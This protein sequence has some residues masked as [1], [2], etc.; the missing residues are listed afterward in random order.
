MVFVWIF[1]TGKTLWF[2]RS[3]NRCN[4]VIR[5]SGSSGYFFNIFPDKRFK[6]MIRPY[7]SGGLP[8]ADD[9][10]C[11]NALITAALSD[12]ERFFNYFKRFLKTFASI[13]RVS[14]CRKPA[15]IACRVLSFAAILAERLAIP[16]RN[17]RL[18]IPITRSRR[19]LLIGFLRQE[20]M[21]LSKWIH[22]I[23]PFWIKYLS[24]W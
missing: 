8:I 24:G 5:D 23:P 6:R 10:F 15:P 11:M 21:A 19:R 22:V 13:L 12:S 20:R 1:N 17:R 4:I 14:F 16:D 7:I 3:W 9:R 2:Y 18:I